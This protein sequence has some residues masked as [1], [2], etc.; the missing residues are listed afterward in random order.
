MANPMRPQ[1]SDLMFG[2]AASSPTSRISVAP[3]NEPLFCPDHLGP[4]QQA[5]S[6]LRVK[7][8]GGGSRCLPALVLLQTIFKLV[9]ETLVALSHVTPNRTEMHSA[10][11]LFYPHAVNASKDDDAIDFASTLISNVRNNVVQ[12]C[13][14]L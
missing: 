7:A 6:N 2:E 5:I 9:P 10:F 3:C 8:Q 1:Q 11:G 12:R 13:P 4:S 14:S